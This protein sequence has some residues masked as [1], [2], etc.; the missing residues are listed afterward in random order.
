MFWNWFLRSAG[1]VPDLCLCLESVCSEFLSVLSLCLVSLI[2][3]FC[4]ESMS[5]CFAGCVPDH[6][7]EPGGVDGRS[8]D[9]LPRRVA[10]RDAQVRRAQ[11]HRR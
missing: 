2:L 5:L 4:T 9:L 6:A 7:V 1:C 10:G 8:Q 11:V 3:C